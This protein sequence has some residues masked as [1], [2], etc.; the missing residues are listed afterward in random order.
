MKG[1]SIEL[2]RRNLEIS[3]NVDDALLQTQLDRAISKVKN[4]L[5]RRYT[6]VVIVDEVETIED[7]TPPDAVIGAVYELA[8]SYYLNRAGLKSEDIDGLSNITFRTED[9]ILEGIKS[10]RRSA[11][12]D[13]IDAPEVEE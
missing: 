6:K 5:N 1:I 8:T 13:D 10:F 9:E 7:I 3:L 2:L 4:R 11:W 12:L